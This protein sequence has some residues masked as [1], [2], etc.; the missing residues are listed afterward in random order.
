MLLCYLVSFGL[1]CL[2]ALTDIQNRVGKALSQELPSDSDDGTPA[3]AAKKKGK[4]KRIQDDEEDEDAVPV[5]DLEGEDSA[6]EGVN[7][8]SKKRKVLEDDID[9]EIGET[10]D[11]A[12]SD[13]GASPGKG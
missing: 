6:D 2:F 13:E 8:K 5:E 9:L 10:G 4:G 3:R 1:P 11:G 7:V 12:D